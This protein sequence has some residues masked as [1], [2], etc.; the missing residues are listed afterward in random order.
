MVHIECPIPVFL[1]SE[2]GEERGKEEKWKEAA[3]R[4]EKRIKRRPE[5][6]KTSKTSKTPKTRGPETPKG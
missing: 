5:T 2:K 3:A 4:K 6:S 1:S